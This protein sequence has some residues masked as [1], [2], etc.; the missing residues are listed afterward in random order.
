MR[1]AAL[2]TV[3]SVHFCSLS[4]FQVGRTIKNW[5]YVEDNSGGRMRKIQV[6]PCGLETVVSRS[7]L[8]NR[9]HRPIVRRN[10]PSV[11][12]VIR[13]LCGR[14][15][16]RGECD[17]CVGDNT[18]SV[19]TTR[20]TRRIR[21]LCGRQYVIHADDT[22]YEENAT[23]VW[24]VIRRLCEQHE[25]RGEY[26]ACMGGNTSYV[27]TRRKRFIGEESHGNHEEY[28]ACTSDNTL[29]V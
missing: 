19:W 7:T 16:I 22:G 18:T 3:S 6:H 20:D 1:P 26:N 25:I 4:G 5:L 23:P 29:Y 9:C 14:H 21:R 17:A 27:W 11:W 13:R 28:K 8:S 24:A 15:A 10:M 12:T 2:F